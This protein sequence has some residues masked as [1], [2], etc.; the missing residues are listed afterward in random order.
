M[1]KGQQQW[2]TL[3]LACIG[4][5]AGLTGSV[6]AAEG[7]RSNCTVEIEQWAD[8]LLAELPGYANRQLT[9]IKAENRVLVAGVPEVERVNANSVASPQDGHHHSHSEEVVRLFFSMLEKSKEE[10]SLVGLPSG[11][12][13][14]QSPVHNRLQLFYR[15]TLARSQPNRPWHL[16][17]LEMATPRLAPTDVTG[18][19]IWQAIAAWQNSG[20][21]G[22]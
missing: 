2:V 15:L 9:R 1:S 21:P 16:I 3:A 7:D 13:Q 14:T 12:P 11:N 18:G 4:L 20:C 8:G 17:S 5:L 19:A 22:T 6:W 10:K